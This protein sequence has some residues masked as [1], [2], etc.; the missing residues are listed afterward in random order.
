VWDTTTAGD[1]QAAD[2]LGYASVLWYT[3][4]A[5]GEAFTPGNEA[6]AAAYLDAG[7]NFFLSSQEYLD[8]AQPGSF[9]TDYLH[10]AG[11]A[12]DVKQT[13]VTG[14]A[15]FAGL[16][17]YALQFPVGFDNQSD[18]VSPAV[19]AQAA[20]TGNKGAAALSY[21]DDTYQSIFFA[22]PLEAIHKLSDRQAVLDRILAPLAAVNPGA[23]HDE[24]PQQTQR[25]L[26]VYVSNR[27]AV[28]LGYT[29]TQAAPASWLTLLDSSGSLSPASSGAV[30]VILDSQGLAPG[31]YTTTLRIDDGYPY[32][33]PTSLPVE[34]TVLAPCTSLEGIDFTWTPA[35]VRVGETVIFRVTGQSLDWLSAGWQIGETAAAGLEAAHV[36]ET[37]GVSSVAATVTNACG[38]S[39]SVTHPVVVLPDQ[40]PLFL[41]LL[42]W[43]APPD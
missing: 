10:L 5:S 3:G 21:R 39:V 11:Y 33:A 17:L 2:L 22:F 1:P 27:G 37:A 28:T 15:L 19:E 16:G 41:P 14:A 29:V 20:F 35:Q 24:L 31:V 7:G 8:P 30:Q 38:Q 36:F 42:V 34:M 25:T 13:T 4:A 26:E 32:T 40:I 43:A 12:E 18:A 6:S 9:E 23:I